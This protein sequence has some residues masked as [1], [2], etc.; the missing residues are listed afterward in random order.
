[1]EWIR[2]KNYYFWIKICFW[3]IFC[4]WE[5]RNIWK[6]IKNFSSDHAQIIQEF[7]ESFDIISQSEKIKDIYSRLINVILDS[8]LS[9]KKQDGSEYIKEIKIY[10]SNST[11]NL[12]ESNLENLKSIIYENLKE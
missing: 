3:R 4:K 6:Y 5:S 10:D 7:F 12:N 2:P 8:L 11:Q 9:D 1:M